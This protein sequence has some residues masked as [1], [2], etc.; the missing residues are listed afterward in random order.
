MPQ[1]SC[2]T[3]SAIAALQAIANLPTGRNEDVMAGHE[4]AYR[5]VEALFAV[6]PRIEVGSTS[7]FNSA[8][9]DPTQIRKT[10]ARAISP[11]E[12]SRHDTL[13]DLFAKG[14]GAGSQQEDYMAM[15]RAGVRTPG[16][17][18]LW[19]MTAADLSAWT[20]RESLVIADRV[21]AALGHS[22]PKHEKS[23][24]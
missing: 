22:F 24:A 23:N 8:V 15:Y 16:E 17:A 7:A 2:H 5:A 4:D 3:P 10:I 14:A 13:V 21:L 1:D 11:V 18:S 20:L 6:P 9:D 19:L 12:W